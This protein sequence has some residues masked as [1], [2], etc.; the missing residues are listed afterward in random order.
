MP[1]SFLE[2]GKILT[3]QFFPLSLLLEISSISHKYW[4]KAYKALKTVL[5]TYILSSRQV[6]PVI[7][8][9]IIMI[10]IIFWFLRIFSCMKCLRTSYKNSL[11]SRTHPRT[12]KCILLHIYT[13]PTWSRIVWHD[14]IISHQKLMPGKAQRLRTG[15]TRTCWDLLKQE[16]IRHLGTALFFNEASWT[17]GFK[18]RTWMEW[19]L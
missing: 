3:S 18:S 12:H 16:W 10:I 11:T 19:S 2:F 13:L 14:G 7:I 5:Y 9:D 15:I 17:A 8:R 1:I 6:S 4:I